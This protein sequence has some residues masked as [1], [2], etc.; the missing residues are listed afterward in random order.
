MEAQAG[1]VMAGGGSRRAPR[2]M[3]GISQQVM[4]RQKSLVIYIYLIET[5]YSNDAGG[6]VV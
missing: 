6:L 4:R 2:R 5:N 3:S 1:D